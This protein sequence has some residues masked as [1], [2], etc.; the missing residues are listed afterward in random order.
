[1]KQVLQNLKTGEIEVADLPGP[2]QKAGHLLIRTRVSLIS[3]G[4]E[5]MLLEFGRAN[6][7]NKAR[8]QPEK[9]RQVVDK[10]K[11]DG[12]LPTIEAV[13]TK[14][15]QP[16]PV[17]YCNV[18]ELLDGD[19]D[20]GGLNYKRGD[21][22]VSNGAHAEI[23]CVPK[24]ICA[25]V[26]DE[27]SD[28]EASFTA[29]GAIGLQGIRLAQPTIGEFF[30]VTG[31]G[32]IGLLTI[33]LLIANGCRVLGVDYDSRK[34]DLA[35]QFGAE[36]VDLSR[37]EDPVAGA[38]VFAGGQ[39]VDGVLITASTTSSQPVHQAAQMCRKRGRIILVGVAGLQFKR[40]D[41]YEKELTFQVSC[42][43]GPGRYDPE[44]EEKGHDYPLGF[45]RW[46]EQ[47]NFQA[48]LDLMASRKLDVK[49]LISHRFTI[50]QAHQAYDLMAQSDEWYLGIILEYQTGPFS[51]AGKSSGAANTVRLPAAAD[52]GSTITIG[53]LGA[54]NF[55]ARILLPAIAD[56]G[57]RLKTIVSAGGISGTH[58]GK[59]FGF[60]ESTTDVA[61][62]FSDPQI[63]AV[64]IAT[65]HD[66]HADYIVKALRAKKHVFVEKPLC[67]TVEELDT[68]SGLLAES[69]D[70]A[71]QPI[72][73]VGFNR[74]FAPHIEKLKKFLIPVNAPKYILMTI[75]AGLIPATHWTQDP[76]IGG[77]RIIGEACHFIDLYRHLTGSTI[78]SG[79]IDV[80]GDGS[81][82]TVS[83]NLRSKDGSLGIIQYLANGSK[84]FPKERLE[85]FCAGRVLQLDNFRVLRGFGWPGFKK[86][87]LWRQNKGHSKEIKAFIAAVSDGRPSPI[88]F[89]E[90]QEVT[91]ITIDL[92]GRL[93]H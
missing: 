91:R 37:N 1:M 54:G 92:A 76:A 12:L 90:I 7:L 3:A 84:S 18:G 89:D 53:L 5:R 67:L 13:R 47:R 30:V 36:T 65:R 86:M 62:V 63:N 43:Y 41:F 8:R 15:D 28:E 21:R 27:V 29:I 14:L 64:F 69:T 79:S 19:L 10:V 20:A 80:L 74:R 59:K 45:V 48:I 81:G 42:S 55:A 77:G 85:V 50:E 25:A 2:E 32:L 73:M 61:R 9:V 17:G 66:T 68:I 60:E 58:L 52:E 31:L 34:C 57:C 46:T 72:L 35:R 51:S 71:N 93:L 16:L 56:T 11:T 24:S 83:M 39:G 23:V 87:H 38:A 88:A 22:I 78:V 26:P 4:T 33:Q 49:P 44:Y 70:S 6:M 82:D 75:N 40:S